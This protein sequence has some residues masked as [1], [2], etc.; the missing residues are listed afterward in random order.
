MNRRNF[1]QVTGASL[2]SLV[3][4]SA[5]AKEVAKG[6]PFKAKF[7]PSPGQLFGGKGKKLGYVDQLK[8]SYDLGFRA[9][10]DN[11]LN[12][13]KNALLEKIAE[14]MK[15]KKMEFGVSVITGGAGAMFNKPTDEQKE[16]VKKD[17]ERGIEVA[18]ITGQTNMTMIPGARDESMTR[19][20]QIKAS[21]DNMRLC[22]DLV[23]EHGIIMAQ[24]PLSHGVK[25]GQPLI[26]SFEDGHLLCKL[27]DRKS[28]KL[29]ADFYHEG[30]IG[31]GEKLIENATKTWDQVSYVQY[32]ASPGRKEPGTGKLDYVAVTQ[33]LREKNYTGI[34]GMEHGQSKKGQEGLDALIAAYRK[35][36]A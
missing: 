26:R 10:E 13:Q 22:C 29:L 34:I 18:K 23:E 32:G 1:S 25:G 20:E 5:L 11:G 31:N 28:C 8:L 21:V 2:L 9:W 36:D 16:R 33:F 19:E 3:G 24:E 30:Q 6:T 7:A 14:F 4:S 12:G 27:V 15:D 35:I 17:L